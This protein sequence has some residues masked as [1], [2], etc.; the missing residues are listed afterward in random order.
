MN[1]YVGYIKFWS[2]PVGFPGGDWIDGYCNGS[3]VCYIGG[4]HNLD[5][6]SVQKDGSYQTRPP[7]TQAQNPGGF[8][9]CTTHPSLNVLV[10]AG[11][12]VAFAV[13]FIGVNAPGQ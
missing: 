10:Y 13:Q 6:L 9:T 4:L 11:T 1:G 3:A 7:G 12:G 5:E 2:V 8:E